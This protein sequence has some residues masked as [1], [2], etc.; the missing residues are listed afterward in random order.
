MI[1]RVNKEDY[2]VHM[3]GPFSKVAGQME[4]AEKVLS[5][6]KSINIIT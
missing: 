5:A 1:N 2:R 6:L 3:H 4:N